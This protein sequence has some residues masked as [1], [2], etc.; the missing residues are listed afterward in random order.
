MTHDSSTQHNE[1]EVVTDAAVAEHLAGI[2]TALEDK[3]AIDISVL[4]L[5]DRS[6]MA[7]YFVV[8]SGN[9]KTHTRAVSE[10]AYGYVKEHNLHVYSLEGKQEGLWVLLDIGF[11]VVHIMQAEEREFYNL[12]QLWSHA[13]Q[14]QTAQ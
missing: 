5:R 14:E 11:I 3:K 7:D 9:S 4:D 10:A 6:T 12:E 1:Q 2:Q 13:Q 8:C